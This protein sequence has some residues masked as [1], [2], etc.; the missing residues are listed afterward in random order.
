[1][2]FNCAVPFISHA[3]NDSTILDNFFDETDRIRNDE[4]FYYISFCHNY[5]AFGAIEY[6]DE[7]IRVSKNC[8]ITEVNN[9]FRI[10]RVNENDIIIYEKERDQGDWNNGKYLDW[11]TVS[12]EK[13]VVYYVSASGRTYG[14]DWNTIDYYDTIN[15]GEDVY[16]ISVS[17]TPVL[18]GNVDR[19][20]S[21]GQTLES[22]KMTVTNHS[23]FDVQICMAI[24]KHGSLISFYNPSEGG[25]LALQRVISGGNPVFV[26]WSETPNYCFDSL[27]REDQNFAHEHHPDVSTF[28]NVEKQYGPCPWRI[29]GKENGVLNHT[30]DWSQINLEDHGNY[31]VFVYALRNDYGIPSRQAFSDSYD[32]YVDYSKIHMVYG[33]NFTLTNGYTFDPNNKKNGTYAYTG[34]D[35]LL[36]STSKDYYDGDGNLHQGKE[37]QDLIDKQKEREGEWYSEFQNTGRYIGS[38]ST[39]GSIPSSL[40]SHFNSFMSFV[41]YVFNQLPGDI[42]TIYIYGF[43]ALVALGIVLKVMK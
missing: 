16:D 1:M 38:D 29:V 21:N 40:K 22:F 30:F 17:F 27:V 41:S 10:D 28:Y 42:K 26:W 37:L 20:D 5:E 23:R 11:V 32:Y 4:N 31:D 13:K 7:V 15:L 39:S 35:V 24:V 33:S 34:N 43:V 18:S 25:Q 3:D 36:A 9:G 12:S 8:S 2:I 6:Y 19:K 14:N